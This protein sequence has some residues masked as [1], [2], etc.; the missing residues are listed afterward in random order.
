MGL[1]GVVILPSVAL[2]QS[3]D[4]SIVTGLSASARAAVSFTFVLAFG[5]AVLYRFG[6]FVDHSIDSSMEQPF[7]SF[8]YGVLAYVFVGFI[9]AYTVS[10]VVQ[11][12]IAVTILTVVS[13][14][15]MGGIMLTLA[16]LGYTVIGARITEMQGERRPWLGLVIGATVS[17]LWWLF[18]PFL[19]GLLAWIVVAA[20]GVGGP[21]RSWLHDSRTAET[22]LNT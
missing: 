19:H 5:A 17:G 22:E 20:V 12:G 18:L 14:V 10:Q 9:S 6:E 2:A 13:L 21:T 11:I 15:F 1:T 7:V 16:G 4:L 3:V 8:I